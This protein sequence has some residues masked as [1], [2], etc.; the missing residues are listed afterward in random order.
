VEY[1]N[2]KL[3]RKVRKTSSDGISK[4]VVHWFEKIGELNVRISGPMI[5]E[6]AL[7]LAREFVV[8]DF[9]ASSGCLGVLR[10]GF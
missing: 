5:Q 6:I 2:C 9:R 7:R 10:R 4:V 8:Q 1:E 3:R